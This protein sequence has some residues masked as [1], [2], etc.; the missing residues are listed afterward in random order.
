MWKLFKQI[1]KTW[2]PQSASDLTSTIRKWCTRNQRCERSLQKRMCGSRCLLSPILDQRPVERPHKIDYA[3]EVP[4][5]ES[6]EIITVETLICQKK[7]NCDDPFHKIMVTH[8]LDS[9]FIIRHRTVLISYEYEH[10]D[11][12]TGDGFKY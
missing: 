6:Y 8:R 1:W 7:E 12:R 9:L 4:R 3:K 5:K 10:P 11:I 2:D